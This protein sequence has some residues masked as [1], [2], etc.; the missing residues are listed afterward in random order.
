MLKTLTYRL[1]EVKAKT[2]SDSG[3]QGTGHPI[4]CHGSRD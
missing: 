3:G 1:A 4:C 2:V